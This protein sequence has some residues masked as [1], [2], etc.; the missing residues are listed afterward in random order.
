MNSKR[1]KKVK[2]FLAVLLALVMIF[3]MSVNVFAGNDKTTN[4]FVSEGTLQKQD[5]NNAQFHCNAVN[6]NGRVWPVVPTDMKKFDGSLVFEKAAGTRWDL[7]RVCNKDG[8]GLR[9]V[10]CPECGSTKWITFSNNSGVPDGKNVQMQ[11]PGENIT[12]IKKWIKNK[13]YDATTV[14]FAKFALELSSGKTFMVGPGKYFIPEY[15]TVGVTEVSCTDGF[16][17]K[18]EVV[19]DD[20]KV[21]TFVNEDNK[22][23]S[24][25]IVRYYAICQLWNDI[26]WGND[27]YGLDDIINPGPYLGSDDPMFPVGVNHR[28]ELMLYWDTDDYNVR[29]VPFG[30]KYVD[31][32]LFDYTK[33]AEYILY[34]DENFEDSSLWDR[35][36]SMGID[37]EAFILAYNTEGFITRNNLWE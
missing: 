14:F 31:G 16:K 4:S 30:G 37:V 28:T 12:I 15:L 29:Y 26:V 17:I 33:W 19:S 22:F 13:E 10:V 3:G 1:F 25:D 35:C 18:S 21:F 11:H 8:V 2:R 23:I 7:S 6:G 20:G 5:F 34:G 27:G 24:N 9:E 36:E 32:R